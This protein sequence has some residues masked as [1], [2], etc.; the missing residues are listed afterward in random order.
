MH[1]GLNLL[2]LYDN[3]ALSQPHHFHIELETQLGSRGGRE[4]PL[5]PDRLCNASMSIGRLSRYDETGLVWLLRGG[6]WWLYPTC[7]LRPNPGG[8]A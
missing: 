6:R 7:T 1:A 3:Y 5:N 8:G 2:H 4:G